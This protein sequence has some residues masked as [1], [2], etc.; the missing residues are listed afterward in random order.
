MDGDV[1]ASCHC[2]RPGRPA[3]ATGERCAPGSAP[4]I[5]VLACFSRNA[6][7]VF[8]GL[9]PAYILIGGAK[10]DK[11]VSLQRRFLK[12]RRAASVFCYTDP[13]LDPEQ[14][15]RDISAAVRRYR[16][17]AIIATGT[18]VTDALSAAKAAIEQATGVKVMVEDF[19]KHERMA[20]KWQTMLLCRE[21][22]IP[23][24]R[25]VLLPKLKDVK[26]VITRGDLK[27][28]I[29]VKPRRS[30]A[31]QGIRIFRDMQAVESFAEESACMP[32]GGDDDS[33]IAQELVMGELHDVTSHCD[34]GMPTCLL[35]QRRLVTASDFGGGGLMNITTLEPKIMEYARRILQHVAWNGI[36]E[37]DFIKTS[38]G[39]YYLLECNPKIWGT[40]YLTMVAGHNVAQQMVDAQLFSRALRPS[41][42]YEVGLLYRWLFP[43]CVFYWF[44]S[45]RSPGRI[46]SRL[47][48]TWRSPGAKRTITEFRFSFLF[49]LLWRL[50]GYLRQRLS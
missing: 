14:F 26:A 16:A 44:S 25:T 1:L 22:Q 19:A 37:F 33:F 34:H 36:A 46:V 27:L 28:P 31:S 17:D 6:L 39:D 32:P 20:D 5:I 45:P 11:K 41:S 40:T 9:D 38:E 35:S 50:P 7:A 13:Q 42:D 3:K 23:T 43:E 49:Y 48:R 10:R 2:T 29:L 24:P 47:R 18:V 4:T 30:F 12:P 8:R 15:Q 21:L